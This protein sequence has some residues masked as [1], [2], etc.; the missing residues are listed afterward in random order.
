MSRTGAH[1][2]SGLAIAALA[3]GVISVLTAIG[4]I[5][6]LNTFPGEAV[7]GPIVVAGPVLALIVALCLT[8]EIAAVR[9]AQ[10]SWMGVVGLA[11]SALPALLGGYWLVGAVALLLF[12]LSH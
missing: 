2:I 6:W 4:T 3:A 8:V 11:L 9:R 12:Q 1:G 7:F 10:P 5:L